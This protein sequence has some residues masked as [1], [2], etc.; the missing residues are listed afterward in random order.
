ML[1]R[2]QTALLT[3]T[4][5]ALKP[6]VR[7][8]LRFGI[9]YGTVAEL[10]RGL[11][12]DVAFE[13]TKLMNTRPTVSSV[14]AVTGLTRKEVKRL[15]ELKQIESA[16]THERYNR[17]IRCISGWVNDQ[18]FLDKR[19]RP[20]RLPLESSDTPSF[21]DLVKRYSGDIPPATMLAVLRAANIV[22][23]KKGFVKLLSKAYVPNND[24]ID[25]IDILGVD[26]AELIATI[27]HNLEQEDKQHRVF[28]RKVSNRQIK[29]EYIEEFKNIAFKKSQQLLEELDGY[30]AA[31]EAKVNQTASYVS[32]GIY[33]FDE[34][35]QP[36][37][38]GVEND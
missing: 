27:A 20:A 21:A 14:A 6:L 38:S 25:V 12:V 30:L 13:N 31:N 26:T 18:D 17:S 4:S 7:V 5:T 23:L 36:L 28:Q 22:E 9:D 3:A 24:P 1:N 11:F 34:S 19:F 29:P 8:L 33:Y 15:K 35:L 32:L 10:L 2:A 37:S 16:G